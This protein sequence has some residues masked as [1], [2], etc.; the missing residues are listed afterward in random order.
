MTLPSTYAEWRRC[1]TVGC[2]IALTPTYIQV[3]LAALANPE[4]AETRRFTELYGE[5][6]LRRIIGWFERAM[7]EQATS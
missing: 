4:E 5:A 6:H 2:G 1:I 3:R 7:L